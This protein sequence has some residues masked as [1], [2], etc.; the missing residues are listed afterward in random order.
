MT[1]ISI[2]KEVIRKKKIQGQSHILTRL[3]TKQDVVCG[4]YA[5]ICCAHRWL[6][7]QPSHCSCYTLLE[8]KN[9]AGALLPGLSAL[10]IHKINTRRT[11]SQSHRKYFFC[12]FFFFSKQNVSM[13]QQAVSAAIIITL[14]SLLI[15]F[16]MD[17]C[18]IQGGKEMVLCRIIFFSKKRA[19]MSYMGRQKRIS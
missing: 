18:C 14:L 3:N 4:Q 11:V 12:Y 6:L 2:F 1:V 8:R 10:H 5:V 19:E 7:L 15:L 16:P 17:K 9:A 13:S